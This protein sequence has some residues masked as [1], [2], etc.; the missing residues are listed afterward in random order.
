MYS[1]S[2]SSGVSPP[3]VGIFFY[4]TQAPPSHLFFLPKAGS[5]PKK[6]RAYRFQCSTHPSGYQASWLTPK[7]QNV[8]SRIWSPEVSCV[9]IYRMRGRLWSWLGRMHFRGWPIDRI[10]L[11][12]FSVAVIILLLLFGWAWVL[13]DMHFN[14]CLQSAYC[15]SYEQV[16][17][18][19]HPV[20][21]LSFFA[22]ITWASIP[23]KTMA[24]WF[25]LL[26]SIYYNSAPLNYLTS[27]SV[28]IVHRTLLLSKVDA[29]IYS[30]TVDEPRWSGSLNVPRH[31]IRTG[32]R[33]QSPS[34]PILPV[35]LLSPYPSL[36][37]DF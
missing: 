6:A 20:I 33:V 27:S 1:R 28:S 32:F 2:F 25:Y 10:P 29:I 24:I 34:R 19:A 8:L 3:L 26:V 36:I 22:E 31:L 14:P 9:D 35:N 13:V 5:H 21:L 11:R 15:D 12:Y 30:P 18:I 17:S 4:S 7:K 37:E 23:T 16:A